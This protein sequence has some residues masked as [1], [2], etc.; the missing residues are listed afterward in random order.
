RYSPLRVTPM[1]VLDEV[2]AAIRLARGR[3]PPPVASTFDL[4]A[5]CGGPL[6]PN[7]WA[8]IGRHLA[9]ELPPLVFTQGHWFLPDGFVTI[10]DLVDRACDYHP[11]WERPV[12]HTVDAWREAQI[13]AG[14]RTA[15][16]EASGADPQAITRESRFADLFGY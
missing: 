15:L 16:A 8:A 14:V 13:F 12:A 4:L 5:L 1:R 2:A 10:W 6:V 7:R 11:D 9:C 3:T